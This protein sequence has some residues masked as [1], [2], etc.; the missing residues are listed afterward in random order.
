[1]D[2]ELGLVFRCEVCGEQSHDDNVD[3][4]CWCEK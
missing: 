1:M 2:E 3:D 4:F